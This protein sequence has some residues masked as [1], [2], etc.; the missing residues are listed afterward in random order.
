MLAAIQMPTLAFLIIFGTPFA[1]SIYF[2]IVIVRIKTKNP[3]SS[4]VND[5]Y[6]IVRKEMPKYSEFYVE[7][8]EREKAQCYELN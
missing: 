7:Q 6:P 2:A 3:V 5:I 4:S 1:L 8:G